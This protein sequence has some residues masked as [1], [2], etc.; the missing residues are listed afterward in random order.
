MLCLIS[1]VAARVQGTLPKNVDTN[2]DYLSNESKSTKNI[3]IASTG[4]TLTSVDTFNV[5]DPSPTSPNISA[6]QPVTDTNE[7]TQTG[8]SSQ[9]LPAKNYYAIQS[10]KIDSVYAPS[11]NN[12]L[13]RTMTRIKMQI[14][15][16]HGFKLHEDIRNLAKALNYD[17]I[18]PG[19]VL[20][21]VDV[22]FRGYDQDSGTW[23]DRIPLAPS[24]E[25]PSKLSYYV[26]ISRIEATVSN[27]GTVYEVDMVPA[28]HYAYRPEEVVVQA[29]HIFTGESST[30]GEFLT[31]LGRRLSD[32]KT[33]YTRGQVKRNY[34]FYAPD[35]IS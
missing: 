6:P 33:K 2:R 30:F 18:N 10:M 8:R 34:R 1:V 32:A 27:I 26:A 7:L 29:N 4:D 14:V 16:P 17:Q 13:I 21:Q 5:F 24:G 12:P 20:Y 19:R 28:G 3:T 25:I 35:C 15:E 31:N 23:I 9:Q 22:H 11:E